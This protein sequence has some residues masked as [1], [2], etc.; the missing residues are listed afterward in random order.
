MLIILTIY[1][2]PYIKFEIMLQHENPRKHDCVALKRILRYI[3]GTRDY[4]ILYN[5]SKPMVI[6]EFSDAH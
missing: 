4:G 1:L 6:D 3:S 2:L 5:V